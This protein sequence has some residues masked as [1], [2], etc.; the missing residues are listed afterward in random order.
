MLPAPTESALVDGGGLLAVVLVA[1]D[2]FEL[3][4]S[5]IRLWHAYTSS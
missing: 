1:A 5:S 3:E 4:L 2:E